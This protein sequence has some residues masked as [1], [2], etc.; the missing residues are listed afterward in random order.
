MVR[1]WAMPDG[2]VCGGDD[3]DIIGIRMVH[4]L[5]PAQR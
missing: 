1:L 5:G 3:V 2:T 4:M